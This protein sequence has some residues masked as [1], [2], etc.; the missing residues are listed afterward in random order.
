MTEAD[1]AAGLRL[2]RASG[3]NQTLADWSL[4]LSLGPGLFRVGLAGDRIVAS[5][6]AVRY[7]GALAWICMILVD[8]ASRGRGLGTRVFDEVLSGLRRLVGAGELAAVG[9]DA[10]PEGRP[11]YAQRGFVAAASLVRMG[12][13]AARG[14]AVVRPAAVRAMRPADLPG[15]RALDR[16]VF[17]AERSA[18]LQHA[19]ASAPDL[20]RVASHGQEM[21]GFCLGRH[22]E[23]SDHLGP[24]IGD[25]G[26][27][28]E[29]VA[30]CLC[31]QRDRP[32]LVDA[33]VTA[34]WLAALEALGFRVQRP[35]TRM[36][37]GD[38]RPP[39]RPGL[40]HAVRGP[41]FG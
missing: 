16:E 40:E 38:P 6:G 37:L 7:G 18:L 17:G 2:S 4:L 32:L 30:G 27:A 36:Y 15:V 31:E 20:A 39:A 13:P 19:L 26:T 34:S 3:W 28:R 9:L 22:G 25:A 1:L 29:L 5:G 33:R 12:V 10:T 11:I 23:H 24:V 21:R 14:G 41:E 35:F 8:P